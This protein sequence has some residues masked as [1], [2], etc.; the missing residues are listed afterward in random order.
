GLLRRPYVPPGA[1]HSAH[2]YYVL[3]PAAELRAPLIEA[4]REHGVHAVFHYVPLHSSPAGAKFGRAVGSLETTTN[5][6]ERLLRLPLWVGLNPDEVLDAF[7][8]A[9]QEVVAPAPLRR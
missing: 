1:E 4:L 6:S 5:L 8:A 9:V 2:L 3:L 7:V